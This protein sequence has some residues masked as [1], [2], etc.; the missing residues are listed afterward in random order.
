[1]DFLDALRMTELTLHGPPRQVVI[2]GIQLEN[3]GWGLSLSPSVAAA[4]PRAAQLV[5]AEISARARRDRH[6]PMMLQTGTITL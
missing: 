3:L 6:L 4:V 1:M 5:L 2:Y